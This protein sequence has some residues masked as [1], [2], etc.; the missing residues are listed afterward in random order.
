MKFFAIALFSGA[1][2]FGFSMPASAQKAKGNGN[3]PSPA[4]VSQLAAMLPASDG[5]ITINTK[6]LLAQAL[7]QVL[8]KK[9][10]VMA[11]MN[12]EIDKFKEKFGIDLRQFEQI[13]AGIRFKRKSEKEFDFEPAM[14]A[15]GKFNS[16]ALIALAKIAANGK[17]REEKI[18]DRNIYIFA[19]KEILADK[20]KQ[21]GSSMKKW[22]AKTINGIPA[23][24][25]IAAFDSSTLAMGSPAMMQEML[26]ENKA[27]IDPG[28]VSLLN[29][30]G[31]PI[32]NVGANIPEGMMNAFI[33]I[34][35]DEIG[36]NIDSIRQVSGSLDSN[37]GNVVL[38]ISALTQETS[39]AE[40]IEN[41]LLGLQEI[42]KA[43]LGGGKTADK[44]VY[45]RM[46]EKVRITRNQNEVVLDL[47]VPQGDIAVLM[48]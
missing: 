12:S 47:Q 41:M 1:L 8:A 44:R 42:G 4:K 17:Y 16:N 43:F 27:A 24:L 18:G 34:D 31:N 7:P 15:R 28:L 48:K 30:R 32:L 45:E 37:A 22:I 46:I 39:Q 21:S 29:K 33:N 25:A 14:L 9:P 5:A 20:E 23:E 11:E 3:A 10:S 2:F 35:N 40:D 26:S 36:K 19:A 13:A 6:K 38:S